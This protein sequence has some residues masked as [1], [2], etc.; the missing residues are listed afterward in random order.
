VLLSTGYSQ[1]GKAR[2]IIDSGI[3]GFIQKPYK[4]DTLLSKVRSLLDSEN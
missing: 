1:S 3:G 2:E 4:I